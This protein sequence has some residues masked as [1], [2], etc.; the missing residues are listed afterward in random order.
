MEE[1]EATN[2]VKSVSKWHAPTDKFKVMYDVMN[3]VQYEGVHPDI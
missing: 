2:H 1:K 3:G